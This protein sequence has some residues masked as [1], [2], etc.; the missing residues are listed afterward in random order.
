MLYQAQQTIP[1]DEPDDSRLKIEFSTQI[2]RLRSKL[3]QIA[4]ADAVCEFDQHR[5]ER[6]GIAPVVVSVAGVNAA[7][8]LRGAVMT[9]EQLAHELLFDLRFQLDESG[10]GGSVENP[11]YHRISES[12][13]QVLLLSVP[14]SKVIF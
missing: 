9:N 4:G 2:V 6:M 12:F 14:F 10:G 8:L 3:Q 1:P 7:Q 13:Q 5:A 11:I